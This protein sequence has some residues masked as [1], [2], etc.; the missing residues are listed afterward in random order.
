MNVE[1]RYWVNTLQTENCL[2]QYSITTGDH[3]PILDGLS[4]WG[5]NVSPPLRWKLPQTDTCFCLW[6]AFFL[7]NVYSV[8]FFRFFS[9]WTREKKEECYFGGSLNC[10]STRKLIFTQCE[11]RS[12]QILETMS[13]AR[14]G[15]K[16]IGRNCIYIRIKGFT[17]VRSIE[18]EQ[19]L[20]SW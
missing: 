11:K 18:L 3:W 12:W 19:R 8:N 2:M 17:T 1:Y 6:A 9:I 16:K 20:R 10:F 7:K 14:K 4:A 15:P 5:Q 13:L